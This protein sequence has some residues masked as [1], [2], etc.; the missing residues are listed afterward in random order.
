[1]EPD[2]KLYAPGAESIKPV[3]DKLTQIAKTNGIRVINTADHHYKGSKELSDKPDFITTFPEHCMADSLGADF[4]RETQPQAPFSDIQ[5]NKAYLPEELVEL[6][7]TR[8][9]IIRKDAFDVF[10]G[11]PHTEKILKLLSPKKIYVYGVTTNV[12]VHCAVTGLAKRDI[13]VIVIED[14]I[15]ELPKIPLPFGEWD[16]L[17][18]K[19]IKSNEIGLPV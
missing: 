13:E 8:N 15:K 14:A 9:I 11:N 12:C 6:T 4:I 16:K 2:G 7:Q 17:G 18:V 5:W 10:E 19:R 3:L 1:M